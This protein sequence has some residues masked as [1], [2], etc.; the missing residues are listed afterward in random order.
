MANT[1]TVTATSQ[2]REQFQ[3]LFNEMW[4]VTGS[5]GDQDAIADDVSVT[6]TLTVPGVALGDMVI[7]QCFNKS[8]ADANASIITSCFVSAANTVIMKLI[9]VDETTDAYDA[10]TLTDGTFKMLIGRPNW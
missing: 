3:G 8:Q 7:G 1:F 9:N 2:N 4:A 10:D 6:L 5:V